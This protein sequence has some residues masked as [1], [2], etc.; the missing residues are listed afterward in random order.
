MLCKRCKK[1]K[2]LEKF[3]FRSDRGKYRTVCKD[4]KNERERTRYVL[5]AKDLSERRKISRNQNLEERREKA[6]QSYWKNRGE[7]LDKARQ[8]PRY[9]KSSPEATARWRVK[10]KP[11]CAAHQAVNRAIKSGK[12]IRPDRCAICATIGKVQAHHS[13]YTKPLDVIFVCGPCHK[14]LHSKFFKDNFPI[15]EINEDS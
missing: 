9:S 1:E 7:L 10:N 8:R 2:G 13:D 4:C 14:K 6:R 15:R 3:E 12:L 5:I 11:K